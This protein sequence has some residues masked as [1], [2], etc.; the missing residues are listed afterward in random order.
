MLKPQ[1]FK[2]ALVAEVSLPLSQA[3]LLDAALCWVTNRVCGMFLGV[4]A[5]V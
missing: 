2:L 4:L 3:G 1:G 5:F